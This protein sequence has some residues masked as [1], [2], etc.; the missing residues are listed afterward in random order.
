[1]TGVSRRDFLASSGAL[2]VSFSAAGAFEPVVS[3]RALGGPQGPF[4]T[5]AS[6]IDPKQLDSWVAVAADGTITAYTGKCE[7][8]Q[9]MLTVQI[10]LIA[11]ELSVPI[12]RVRLVQCDTAVTPDQGTTSGSQSTP[13]NFNERNLALAG[14]TA[15]QALLRLASARLAVPIDQLTLADGVVSVAANRARRVTYAELVAGGRFNVQLDGTAKRTPPSDWKVLGAAVARVDMPAMATGQFEFVHNVRV[16]GMVHGAVVRPPS[17][18]ATLVSVDE[19]S[20]LS[21]PGVLKVV[22]RKNFVGVVAEKPWQAGQAAARL[23]AAWTA[24]AALPSQ[25]EFYDHLRRQPSR[26][27]YVVKSADADEML[28][29]AAADGRLVKATYLHPY[30]MHG[31]MGTSCAVAD[32]RDGKATIWSPTQSA[33]PTR[34]GAAML[35]GLPVENVRVVFTRGA[36]CYGIN[37]ADTVS[38]DAA[39][40]SQA[41]AKPVRVQLSR[42]DEMAWENYGFAFVIDQRVGLDADGAIG[43]WDYEAWSP[44]RGG[45]PGYDAPGNVVTGMLAGYEPAGVTPRRA[46][47]PAGEFRNGSNSAPSYVAGRV[48][49]KAG[50]AGVVASE[51]VLTHTIAS[52]FFTGPLR[53]PSRLQNT[54]AHECFLDEVAAQVK[55]DPVAYRLRHLRDARLKAV[56]SAAARAA[57]WDA[58]PS[59]RPNTPRS[60]VAAGRGL[61]CVAYEG[62]NGYVAMVAE[63]DVDEASGRIVAKRLVVAQDC[64]PI[65]NPDGMRNQIEGGALQG[66]SRAL[67]EEVTWDDRQVTSVDWRT[68]HSLSLG[69]APPAIESVLIH[70]TDVEATGAGE[71]AI[72][73]VAAAIGNAVFDATGARLRQ[74]P[75]TPEAVK[76]ALAS[77]TSRTP[78]A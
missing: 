65:S 61:A 42:K 28:A 62:D 6:H 13:T 76:A 33:Y 52:P 14:A 26:D 2:L 11:E 54:F 43:V 51:R 63:V 58:R 64:G 22:V 9:G 18:G 30:Q 55:A 38:F 60:G 47:E 49:G 31:S 73:V 3:L 45:R 46:P 75:F 10:Q 77:R 48:S 19:G 53:S 50:G 35:L 57:R 44:S 21:M 74:V 36:G 59:P 70:R 40:L 24:G 8:G 27:A 1:M 32:V 71:T 4:D 17:V 41:M 25:R 20:V 37:G 16:P 56:V 29:K 39:L 67:G 5:R 34:S 69:F 66:L 68:Y 7:L 23:K 15:R 12:A 78:S 72:T